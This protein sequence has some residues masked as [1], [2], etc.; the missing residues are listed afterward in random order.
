MEDIAIW[1]RGQVG[2]SAVLDLVDNYTKGLDGGFRL[3]I[4]LE[5]NQSK[6]ALW[7]A[8]WAQVQGHPYNVVYGEDMEFDE[9]QDSVCES[10]I[11]EVS[12]ADIGS[13][14]VN[15]ATHLVAMDDDDET[16][17]AIEAVL[18]SGSRVYDLTDSMAEFELEP[19][20]DEDDEEE[21]TEGGVF[22]TIYVEAAPSLSE[23]LTILKR[24]EASID[25]LSSRL[26]TIKA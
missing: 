14:I 24:L 7:V 17:A 2:R 11:R 13:E 3:I 20:A 5:E 16:V 15:A 9:R 8:E 25:N 4:P 1:G 23:I 10:A 6:S 26:R 21:Y 19:E 18:K 12:G 22:P